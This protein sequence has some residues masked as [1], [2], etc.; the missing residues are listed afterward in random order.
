[1]K[2]IY[3]FGLWKNI[4]LLRESVFKYKTPD[5]TLDGWEWED[6][7]LFFNWILYQEFLIFNSLMPYSFAYWFIKNNRSV[8]ILSPKT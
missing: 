8:F 6:N 5:I 4:L 2:L 1:M 3:G 7:T